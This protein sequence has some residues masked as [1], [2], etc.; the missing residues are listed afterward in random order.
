MK[1]KKELLVEWEHNVHVP[2]SFTAKLTEKFGLYLI[3]DKVSFFSHL[4]V[5]QVAMFF[6][7]FGIM[8]VRYGTVFLD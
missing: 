6:P 2:S 4:I 5:N 3:S 8:V 1:K 7:P